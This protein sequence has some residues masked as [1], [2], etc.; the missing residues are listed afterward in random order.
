MHFE[1]IYI[2]QS[3]TT[4]SLIFNSKR[5]SN[6]VPNHV[7]T[8]ILPKDMKTNNQYVNTFL[9][10]LLHKQSP[11]TKHQNLEAGLQTAPC[12]INKSDTSVQRFIIKYFRKGLNVFAVSIPGGCV[13]ALCTA[14]LEITFLFLST[15]CGKSIK[16]SNYTSIEL[17]AQIGV[18]PIR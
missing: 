5:N 11:F 17:K 10:A 12:V 15:S 14:K 1:F 8:Q 3:I 18:D 4:L 9:F 7:K 13:N 2:Q 16:I 6:V